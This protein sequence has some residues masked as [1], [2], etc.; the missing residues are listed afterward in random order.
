M[1]ATRTLCCGGRG[2]A[3]RG[4]V[5]RGMFLRRVVWAS[6]QCALSSV[7]T[8]L[9]SGYID[10][11][12]WLSVLRCEAAVTRLW[13]VLRGWM[14]GPWNIVAVGGVARP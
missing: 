5:G 9:A 11:F 7:C 8:A 4:P 6:G 3:A 13:G 14:H 10:P 12:G 1:G 2:G